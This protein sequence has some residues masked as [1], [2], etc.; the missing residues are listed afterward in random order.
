MSDRTLK[1]LVQYSSLITPQFRAQL[2]SPNTTPA[3]MRE[4]LAN[5]P[6]NAYPAS[7]DQPQFALSEFPKLLS[8]E[9]RLIVPVYTV[10][11]ACEDVA[12]LEKIRLA[13]PSPQSI[14]V[15]PSKQQPTPPSASTRPASVSPAPPN[16]S[17]P[18]LTVLDEATT[19]VLLIGGV[20]LR[21]FGLGGAV[22]PH[23]L[24]DNGAGTATI[25]GGQGT[26]WTTMLQI[27]ELVDTAQK[28]RPR[29]PVSPGSRSSVFATP[30]DC[31]NVPYRSTILPRRACSSRTPRPGA[32][33]SCRSSRSSSRPT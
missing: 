13:P 29:P 6:K 22:V 2:L 21:L 8:G 14:P 19:R 5:P 20:R 15:D 23:K 28:V 3:L 27:G 31:F 11:G 25:A 9:I 12:I 17:I 7:V 24:F 30:A 18:N 10:W 33:A 1:H 32:R 16:Y 4:L 26:M